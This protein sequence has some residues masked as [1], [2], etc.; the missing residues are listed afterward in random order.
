MPLL[1]CNLVL[2]ILDYSDFE[3][4]TPRDM[5]AYSQKK[6]DT[7]YGVCTHQTST[8]LKSLT[9]LKKAQWIAVLD[10]NHRPIEPA[11]AHVISPVHWAL[12]ELVSTSKIG[13]HGF[14]KVLLKFRPRFRHLSTKFAH[15]SRGSVQCVSKLHAHFIDYQVLELLEDGSMELEPLSPPYSDVAFQLPPVDETKFVFPTPTPY[16][17]MENT[18][19]STA[20]VLSAA[21]PPHP[22]TRT[23]DKYLTRRDV[24]I[25]QC[26][27]ALLRASLDDERICVVTVVALP[28]L[29]PNIY[30]ELP[31]CAF[32]DFTTVQHRFQSVYGR[33]LICLC[34]WPSVLCELVA[35]FTVCGTLEDFV[36]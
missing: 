34:T 26:V 29:F 21:T 13:K 31:V 11:P 10:M 30:K 25:H 18:L 12:L 17:L 20:V 8:G 24:T 1:P 36:Y 6:A 3:Y 14:S 5:Q 15:L 35:Q 32:E 28:T 7:A 19:Q 22:D 9:E 33:L 2:L 16:A 4:A 23:A 27:H